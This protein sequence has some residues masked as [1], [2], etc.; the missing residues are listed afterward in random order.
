DPPLRTDGLSVSVTTTLPVNE[1]TTLPHASS[2]L[3]AGAGDMLRSN[4]VSTGSVDQ[5]SF[6]PPLTGVE[7]L[8]PTKSLPVPLKS[9]D[10]LTSTAHVPGHTEELAEPV[11]S[12]V[13]EANGGIPDP[14]GPLVVM[15]TDDDVVAGVL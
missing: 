5:L 11:T 12:T 15:V 4:S 13:N 1:V 10:C 6:A 3:T 7:T 14:V 8:L 2:M 9:L